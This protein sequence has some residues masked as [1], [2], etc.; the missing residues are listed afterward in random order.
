MVLGLLQPERGEWYEKKKRR[1][2]D[3]K[4]PENV[5]GLFFFQNEYS[6]PEVNI[7]SECGQ[8]WF[9]FLF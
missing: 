8:W 4:E 6:I 2:I 7:I 9:S 1:L 5:Q 3:T